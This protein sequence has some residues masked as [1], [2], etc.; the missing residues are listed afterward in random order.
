MVEQAQLNGLSCFGASDCTAVGFFVTPTSERA[1]AEH[2]NGSSWSMAS[3]PNGTGGPYSDLLGVACGDTNHCEAVGH[4]N[5]KPLL[6]RWVNG[7]GW[8]LQS[9]GVTSGSLAGV[10]CTSATSCIAVGASGNRP[11]ALRWNGSTWTR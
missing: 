9:T 3:A 2:W 7:S 10:V 4:A 11:L 1:L 5:G 8:S 6:E